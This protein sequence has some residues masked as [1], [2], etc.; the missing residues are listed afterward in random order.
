MKVLIYFHENEE[1]QME[2]IEDVSNIA[3]VGDAVNIT[4]D[5]ACYSRTYIQVVKL[6]MV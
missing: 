1:I 5:K 6:E 2:C 3:V 4:F